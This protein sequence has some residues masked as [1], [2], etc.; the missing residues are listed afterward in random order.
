MS[1][2]RHRVGTAALPPV[3]SSAGNFI[4]KGGGIG[5]RREGAESETQSSPLSSVRDSDLCVG[6]KRSFWA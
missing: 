3:V 2:T 6:I 1:S 4:W 5:R